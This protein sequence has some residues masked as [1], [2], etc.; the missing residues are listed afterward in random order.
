[1]EKID[2]SFNITSFVFSGE[3]PDSLNNYI[4][5]GELYNKKDLL[6]FEEHYIEKCSKFSKI[7]DKLKIKKFD[8]HMKIYRNGQIEKITDLSEEVKKFDEILSTN[9]ING[10]EKKDLSISV[11]HFQDYEQSAK[12]TFVQNIYIL[13]F[14]SNITEYSENSFLF[15]VKNDENEVIYNFDFDDIQSLNLFDIYNWVIQSKE[16]LNTRLKIV[17]EFILK[18]G[19]FALVESDLLGIKSAFNRIIK[20]E[21]EKYFEQ[22]NMLREDFFKINK[23]RQENLQSLHLKFLGWGSSIALFVYSELQ[24]IKSKDLWFSL[25]CSKSEKVTL[26]LMIFIMAL[27]II[28]VIYVKEFQEMK[29]EFKKLKKFYIDELF[30]ESKYFDRYI[31]EPEIPKIYVLIFLILLNILIYRLLIIFL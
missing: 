25:F 16:N 17:R 13:F 27:V 23:H 11:T 1:M 26:F 21:T 9:N 10:L 19:S 29:K 20:E 28:W 30:F 5:D 3:Y 14:L 15:K 12:L 18:K 2:G 24:G 31:K 8:E 7:I 4:E 22:V 6:F